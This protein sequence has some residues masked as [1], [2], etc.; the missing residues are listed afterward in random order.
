MK[1]DVQIISEE[2]SGK[3]INLCH[4]ISNPDMRVTEKLAIDVTPLAIVSV[5]PGEAAIVAADFLS[6]YAD[7]EV[8]FID[9]YLGTV[10]VTGLVSALETACTGVINFLHGELAFQ[11]VVPTRS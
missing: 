4:I 5:S 10:L 3:N 2:V 9:R 7:L 6:K 11:E 8:V 1:A